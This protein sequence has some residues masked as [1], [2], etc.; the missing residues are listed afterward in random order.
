M[1]NSDD[2]LVRDEEGEGDGE[3]GE[4][5]KSARER[6]QRMLSKAVSEAKMQA[7][8]SLRKKKSERE[9]RLLEINSKGAYPTTL[10]AK[11]STATGSNNNNDNRNKQSVL[12][13]V[14]V[15]NDN[16]KTESILAKENEKKRK[17]VVVDDDDDD[18]D[19]DE[20][21]KKKKKKKKKQRNLKQKEQK[22]EEKGEEG[23]VMNDSNKI[24]PVLAAPAQA[25]RAIEPKECH[26][27]FGPR[28]KTRADLIERARNVHKAHQLIDAICKA[29]QDIRTPFGFMLKQLDAVQ[30]AIDRN[31]GMLRRDP[32]PWEKYEMDKEEKRE[33]LEKK[34]LESEREKKK[35][36][37]EKE[38]EMC[39]KKMLSI[40]AAVVDNNKLNKKSMEVVV[41]DMVKP[42]DEIA[43]MAIPSHVNK[44]R[45]PG[46]YCQKCGRHEH[47]VNVQ[48]KSKSI[49][50]KLICN[51]CFEKEIKVIEG[52]ARKNE[53]ERLKKID[54]EK[55]QRKKAEPASPTTMNINTGTPTR[56][57]TSKYAAQEL[58]EQTI[59][60]PGWNQ[61]IEAVSDDEPFFDASDELKRKRPLLITNSG[62]NKRM[63]PLKEVLERASEHDRQKSQ[64]KDAKRKD[65][66][67]VQ[68]VIP[69]KTKMKEKVKL[70]YTIDESA[71]EDDLNVW[72]GAPHPRVLPQPFYDSLYSTTLASTY[73]G[74]LVVKKLPPSIH[75]RCGGHE[76]VYLTRRRLIR[77][78]CELETEGC[79][80]KSGEGDGNLFEGRDWEKHCGKGRSKNWKNSVK[81]VKTNDNVEYIRSWLRRF[82]LDPTKKC[83]LQKQTNGIITPTDEDLEEEK[84]LEEGVIVERIRENTPPPC[85]AINITSPSAMTHIHS[86]ASDSE[87][88]LSHEHIVIS[89]M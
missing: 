20:E 45:Y 16:A 65:H 55:K 21:E 47:Q 31:F 80:Q 50:G 83:R 32:Y 4:E 24:V 25:K 9:M 60:M 38:G 35:K 70:T 6:Y 14:G 58:M 81:V 76:G 7:A 79:L 86:Y 75:V 43:K 74:S 51:D 1:G 5:E 26:R 78:M 19:D 27:L 39:E 57:P 41:K 88:D 17:I 69:E 71:P 33:A 40:A 12:W 42:G 56:T 85:A 36:K 22:G 46:E 68:A 15:N 64:K 49:P 10:T 89:I 82:G 13:V 37:K 34:K 23:E 3:D 59:T 66:A 77:C 73:T 8:D 67:M 72:P 61:R 18:D 87:D 29:Q 54:R 84:E 63:M 48:M 2:K 30:D 62:E 28:A 52:E 44:G 11:R 53:K